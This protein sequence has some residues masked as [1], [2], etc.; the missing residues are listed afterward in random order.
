MF[1][2]G[3]L[4]K[5]KKTNTNTKLT[6]LTR[7]NITFD[8]DD[9][10]LDEVILLAAIFFSNQ[11]I[12]NSVSSPSSPETPEMSSFAKKEKPICHAVLNKSSWNQ[13]K[14]QAR[15]PVRLTLKLI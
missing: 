6:W 14:L 2:D 4:V 9:T 1:I 10:S 13:V 15:Q 8:I 5:K 7:S 12:N 3:Q 11:Q